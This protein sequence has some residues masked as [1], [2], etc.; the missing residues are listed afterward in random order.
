MGKPL[1]RPDCL[2]QNPS[3]VGKGE[4]E[5]LNID[6][7]Y[8]PQRSIY[9]TVRLNEQIDCGSKGSLATRHFSGTPPYTQRILD[10]SSLCGNGVLT[11]SSAFEL[12]SREVSRMECAIFDGLK[13]NGDV[14][15]GAGTVLSKHH[16][17][18][19]GEKKKEHP[20]HRC[21]WKTFAPTNEGEYASRGGTLCSD[22]VDR[23]S[24]GLARGRRG[25]SVTNSLTSEEDSGLCSP[26]AE[27][28]RHSNR[29]S[30]KPGTRSLSSSEAMHMS[31]E[32]KPGRS[33]SSGQE[34]FP[35]SPVRDNIPR[36]LYHPGQRNYP[37]RESQ[38]GNDT[39]VT[40]LSETD[41]TITNGEYR[42]STDRR[43]SRSNSRDSTGRRRSSRSASR[44][45][46][47]VYRTL[48]S[49]DEL[50]TAELQE[51]M[52]YQS[53]CELV[54]VVVTQPEPYVSSGPWSEC[55]PSMGVKPFDLQHHRAIEPRKY[56]MEDLEDF[57]LSVEREAC[58]A[59]GSEPRAYQEIRD[60]EIDSLLTAIAAFPEMDLMGFASPQW[61]C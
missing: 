50:P 31:G 39:C 49:Y 21:S 20:L 58:L 18:Q 33:L 6:D 37:V 54:S 55:R 9:D 30:R 3:C 42:D 23:L 57:L 27:R 19:G 15:R 43:S 13:L 34:E 5:D 35:F 61:K 1:S 28:E 22:G 59:N 11:S 36:T 38:E 32:L 26:T 53:D 51:D 45:Q 56:S 8:V 2:R 47:G 40:D 17:G 12:R 14:I 48:A 25:R 46:N 44:V 10:M 7:C 29:A 4:E 52:S 41:L 60:D 24:H 16:L